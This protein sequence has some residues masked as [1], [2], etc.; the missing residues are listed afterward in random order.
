MKI[1]AF[2]GSNSSKSINH[3]LVSYAVKL[4]ENSEVINL[5]DYAVP[6]YSQDLE[7]S[8][9]IPQSI[10][11]LC[12]KLSETNKLVISVCEHNGNISAFF[13][14]ILD[15]LFKLH[16]MTKLKFSFKYMFLILKIWYF[17]RK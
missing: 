17:N 6:I 11:Y 7:N 14:N 10:K 3:Q 1:I 4:V 9:G 13:K 15:E 2:A 5:N 16:M 8:E 12:A